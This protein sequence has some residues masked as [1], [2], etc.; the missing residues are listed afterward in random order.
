MASLQTT[1]RFD[2]LSIAEYSNYNLSKSG[3]E[4]AELPW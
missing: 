1:N 3:L 4:S 2:V